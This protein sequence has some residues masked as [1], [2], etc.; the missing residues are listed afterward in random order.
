MTTQIRRRSIGQ[1]CGQLAWSNAR[2][3]NPQF[4]FLSTGSRE[5]RNSEKKIANGNAFY[6]DFVKRYTRAQRA[7]R[8]DFKGGFNMSMRWVEGSECCYRIG[9]VS[10]RL[11]SGWPGV[12]LSQAQPI[13]PPD[14][15]QLAAGSSRLPHWQYC[16]FSTAVPIAEPPLKKGNKTQFKSR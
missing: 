7:I 1:P 8:A 10:A 5:W 2:P 6:S 13:S 12:L 11:G 16:D 4:H 3:D 15:G 14:D 9:P